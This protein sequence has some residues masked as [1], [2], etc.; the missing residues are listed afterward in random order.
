MVMIYCGERSSMQPATNPRSWNSGGAM[1]GSR[2][3]RRLFRGGERM[4]LTTMMLM[5]IM[6]LVMIPT[7]RNQPHMFDWLTAATD[8]GAA[9]PADKQGGGTPGDNEGAVGAA[10]SEEAKSTASKSATSPAK[11]EPV[12]S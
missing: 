3:G 4:R 10:K 2:D 7:I 6:L 11:S 9:A 8:Q 1:R 5:L 12:K